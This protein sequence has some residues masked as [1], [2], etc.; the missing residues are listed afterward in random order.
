MHWAHDIYMLLLFC[1]H[2]IVVWL[3][4]RQK[5]LSHQWLQ[6]SKQYIGIE[7]EKL[8]DGHM[9]FIE[10]RTATT[11][12]CLNPKN[13]LNFQLR[14]SEDHHCVVQVIGTITNHDGTSAIGTWCQCGMCF[15]ASSLIHHIHTHTDMTRHPLA[16]W[17]E[18][19]ECG[20]E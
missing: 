14:S 13:F 19:E 2:Q 18:E 6:L 4:F 17:N 20:I 7:Y 3:V 16:E 9:S 10:T 1:M 5:I 12:Q 8:S 15:I 11:I